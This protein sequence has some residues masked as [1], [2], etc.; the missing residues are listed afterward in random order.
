MP[1]MQIAIPRRI[2]KSTIFFTQPVIALAYYSSRKLGLGLGAKG[3]L[4]I[5]INRFLLY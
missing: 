3:Q 5:G 4:F 2:L 1:K